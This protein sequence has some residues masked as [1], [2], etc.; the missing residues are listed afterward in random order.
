M[1]IPTPEM[2]KVLET[3]P[4]LYLIFSPDFIILNA[5]NAYLEATLTQRSQLIG[6]HVFEVF[7]EN[8]HTSTPLAPNLSASVE[9]AL[10]TKKP[11]T[12][13]VQ[14]YDI[15]H[16]TQAGV[17]LERY[18]SVVNTPVLDETGEVAYII[19]KVKDVTESVIIQK[20][21]TDSQEREKTAMAKIQ[22]QN[23]WL[24]RLFMQ[25][26]AAIS[27]LHGPD[28]VYTF[29]NPAYQ[30]LFPG[31][32]LL[33]KAL[34]KAL[35]EIK[36]REIEKILWNVMA[37]GESYF[38]T[39]V[40]VDIARHAGGPLEEMY[41]TFIYQAQRDEQ[42]KVDGIVC[43]AF[44]VTELVNSR[45]K[46]E[47][48]RKQGQLLNRELTSTNADLAF[49]NEELRSANEKL[50]TAQE[51]LLQTH[52]QLER[53]TIELEERVVQRT[54]EANEAQELAQAQKDRLEQFFMQAPAAICV[55]DGPQMVFE[56]VN[57]YFSELFSG[58]P[59][60]GKPVLEAVA[61]IEQQP[62]YQILRKTYQSGETYDGK[63]VHIAFARKEGAP[64]E[65]RYFNFIYKPRLNSSGKVDGIMIFAFE[66]TQQV[67][68]RKAV[69]TNAYQLRLIT[70]ALPV[71]IGY[72]DRE[73]KYRFAN[74]AYTAWFNQQPE[75]LLGRPVREVVGDK[76]YMGVK[77]YI[78]RALAG[79]RLDFEAR[80]P[81][82]DNFV[83][84]IHTSYVPDIREGEVVGF[85][86]LV[87]DITES[88][89]NMLRIEQREIEA[90]ALAEELAEVN[91]QL[92]RI[93]SDLD[94]FVYTA[95][96][97]LKAPIINIEGLIKALVRYLSTETL[98]RENV[99]TTLSFIQ[100]AIERFKRT[101]ASL[102]EVVKLQKESS[103]LPTR[104]NLQQIISEIQL[105]LAP[106]ILEAQA[107]IE[108]HV[109]ACPEI[110][111]AEKNLRSIV[112][113]LLSNAIKYR[114]PERTPHI[115]IYCQPTEHYY[116]L[117][118]TDNGLGM[119]LSA[120]QPLFSMFKRFHNHVEGSGI[121]LYM[122][123]RIVENAG[124]KVDVESKIDEGSTFKIY[125]KRPFP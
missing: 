71:L 5:S 122:V 33:G 36:G 55:L 54:K 10:A 76:A 45:K 9:Q 56:L 28:L 13:A 91:A 78:D 106:Q 84:H 39:E 19:Q 83:K 86:T 30:K 42:G 82:R 109:D 40:R 64:L 25:A 46:V 63:E 93:N 77:T 73:E 48:N 60:L 112:Y 65:D 44:E 99:Q 117:T 37:T 88:V 17:F 120:D 81:Y 107:S 115:H 61:E 119:N 4:D 34:F 27:M 47:E 70:D 49:T 29:I 90:Q 118:V 51:E 110:E 35:P 124:G 20:Q 58:R 53:L 121:G 92:L 113:N 66:V 43:F 98:G 85:F 26:P 123:K 2:L 79:E 75:E 108:V 62:I 114:S 69:E 103:Q 41:F 7:P 100:Q 24:E 59:L 6:R 125:F 18:W 32:E 74:K 31:R 104:V 52:Q 96:H 111:F 80:M 14:P 16:P 87:A 57:P 15:P 50:S 23:E 12:M 89:E 21:L 94:T 1:N 11:H 116:L 105:D 38:G 8:L 101:I 68:A 3:V 102:T 72:L 67:E 97:D 22:S 95:S